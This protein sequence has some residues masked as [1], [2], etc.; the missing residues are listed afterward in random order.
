[1]QKPSKRNQ[2]PSPTKKH[3]IP[4]RPVETSAGEQLNGSGTGG[5][6]FGTNVTGDRASDLVLAT[7]GVGSFRRVVLP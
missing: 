5:S 3:L 1:M 4:A 6:D 2:P 7:L